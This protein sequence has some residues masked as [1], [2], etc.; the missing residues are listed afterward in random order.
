V[1]ARIALLIDG[2]GVSAVE[3]AVAIG[4]LLACTVGSLVVVGAVLTRLPADYFRPGARRP[5]VETAHP[6]LH[7]LLLVARNVAGVALI[8]VGVVLSVPGVPGQ[9]LLT[10][11]IGIL[12]V[13]FPGKR[14]LERRILGVPVLLRAV[15]RLRHR[16]GHPPLV[17]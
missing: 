11:F 7:A 5:L 12:L 9:G 6:A 16:R 17:L 15:N 4:I 3:V 1:L 13:D 2:S 8:A 14:R 10:I